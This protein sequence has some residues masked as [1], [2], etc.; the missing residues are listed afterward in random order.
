MY[1]C[2]LNTGIFSNSSHKYIVLQ[3]IFDKFSSLK[4]IPIFSMYFF[5]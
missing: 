4:A 2:N 5:Y 3:K 1:S